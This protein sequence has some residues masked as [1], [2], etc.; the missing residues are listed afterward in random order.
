MKEPILPDV[1]LRAAPEQ[2][3]GK[4]HERRRQ[5]TVLQEK[6]ISKLNRNNLSPVISALHNIAEYHPD[7]VFE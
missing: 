6:H 7:I 3:E 2:R 5:I 4:K 1:F